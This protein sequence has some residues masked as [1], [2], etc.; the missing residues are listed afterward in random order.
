MNYY[1]GEKVKI[2]DHVSEA[3]MLGRVAIIIDTKEALSPHNVKDWQHIKKGL[4]VAFES[5]GSI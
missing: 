4:V 2:G 3:K 1:S 5:N